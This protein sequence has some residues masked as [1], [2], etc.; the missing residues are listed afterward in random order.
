ME[1]SGSVDTKTTQGYSLA[2]SCQG[3]DC[4]GLTVSENSTSFRMIN[5]ALASASGSLVSGVSAWRT[6]NRLE[7]GLGGSFLESLHFSLASLEFSGDCCVWLS[8]ERSFVFTAAP[9]GLF[10]CH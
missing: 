3:C 7:H 9:E 4:L 1:E 10:C 6:V 5:S 2:S 8:L